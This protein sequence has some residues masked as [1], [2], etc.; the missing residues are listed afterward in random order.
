VLFSGKGLKRLFFLLLGLPGWCMGKEAIDGPGAIGPRVGAGRKPGFDRR[1]GRLERLLRAAGR[2][3]GEAIQGDLFK[4]RVGRGSG[5]LLL[6]TG[7][8]GALGRVANEAI[9]G[10]TAAV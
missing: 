1:R 7:R 6:L 10:A 9:Q 8:P 2:V 5:P 4:G 3:P